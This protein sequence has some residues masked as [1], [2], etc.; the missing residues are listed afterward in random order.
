MIQIQGDFF[1]GGCYR[2]LVGFAA[3]RLMSFPDWDLLPVLTPAFGSVFV[4]RYIQFGAGPTG[5]KLFL[6]YSYFSSSYSY[7]FLETIPTFFL[8]FY[9]RPLSSLRALKSEKSLSPPI[10]VG[11]GGMDTNEWCIIAC[12]CFS[13]KFGKNDGS[14]I[15]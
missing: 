4:E 3:P 10:P 13:V 5:V 14:H 2:G 7:F 11:G 6:L 15:L 9:Q 12:T 1:T 8:L